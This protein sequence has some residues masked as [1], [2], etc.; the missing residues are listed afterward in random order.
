[1]LAG[2]LAGITEHAV[3]FPVDSI[4][5]VLLATALEWPRYLHALTSS[6][7]PINFMRTRLFHYDCAC[8]PNSQIQWRTDTYASLHNTTSSSIYWNDTSVH[9]SNQYRRSI[10]LMARCM[11][12][13]SR[14]WT[15]TCGILW[16]IRSGER[17]CRW[18]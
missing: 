14:C 12:C 5:E 8:I 9:E 7:Y 1:M 10:P 16:Y 17:F 2:S 3:I 4:K 6:F 11:E 13:D 15:R 18:K